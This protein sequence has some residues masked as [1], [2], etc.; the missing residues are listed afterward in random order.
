M[1]TTE[2]PDTVCSP[3]P[4]A[5]ALYPGSGPSLGD[6][7]ATAVDEASDGPGRASPKTGNGGPSKQRPQGAPSTDN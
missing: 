2:P 3:S 4:L 1:D 7:G 5:G 6:R